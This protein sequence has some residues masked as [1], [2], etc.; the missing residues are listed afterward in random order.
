MPVDVLN[1]GR[2]RKLLEAIDAEIPGGEPREMV[3]TQQL[4]L[5]VSQGTFP[6]SETV[7]VGRAFWIGTT[8]AVAAV[9]AIPTTAVMMALFNNDVDGGRSLIIDWVAASGVAKTAAAGQQQMLGL[10]GQVRETAPANSAL[11]AKKRNGNGSGGSVDTRALSIVGGTAL[12]AGTGV[13]ANWFPIGPSFGSPGAAA[14]PGNGAYQ[15]VDGDIIVPPGRYFAMHVLAD[16]VGSTYQG[17]V[18]WHEKQITLG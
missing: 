13:A 16:V 14:T 17:F 9:V 18:G 11:V 12:P 15:R 10:I 5:L 3:L 1:L 6:Y 4:E 2:I 8:T 7:R